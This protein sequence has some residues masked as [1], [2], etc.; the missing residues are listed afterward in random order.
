M[1]GESIQ[2]EVL[3]HQCMQAIETLAHV[4]GC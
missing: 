1:S 3:S 4:A 2:M